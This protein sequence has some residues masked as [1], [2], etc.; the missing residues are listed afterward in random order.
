MTTND[1]TG[2]SPVGHLLTNAHSLAEAG[3]FT[4]AL[5]ATRQAKTLEPKNVYVL[6]FEKQT[7]Q[8]MEFSAAG[9][10][11]EEQR[12]DILE[13]MPVI[14]EK[15][16]ELSR[17]SSGV[18]VI[19]GLGSSKSLADI[20]RE[21][22]EKGAALE[23][24]KNQY[25]QH[26][27]EYVRKGEYHH[28]LAEIRRVYIIDTENKVARDFEKQIDQLAQM[29]TQHATKVHPSIIPPEPEGSPVNIT[30]R[31]PEAQSPDRDSVPM[32]TEEWSSPREAERQ[33]PAKKKHAP[34]ASAKQPEGKGTTFLMVMI[35]LALIALGAS[36][37]WYYQRNYLSR[38]PGVDRRALPPPAS[39]QFLGAPGETAEQSFV[40]APTSADTSNTS[41]QVIQL[42]SAPKTRKE[43]PATRQPA[44]ATVRPTP[45][46]TA[47]A[48]APAS[49]T[50]GRGGP[51]P[52]NT[53]GSALP[54]QASTTAPR[55]AAPAVAENVDSGTTTIPFTAVEKEATII[56]L[57]KPVFSAEAFQRGVLGQVVI[58]VEIDATGKPLETVTLKSTNDLLIQPVINA[59]MASKFAPAEVS[60]GP[61]KSWLTI[62]FKFTAK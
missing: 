17:T 52:V 1:G 6:A 27:H 54:L 58:S 4:A 49:G 55:E 5:A 53:A 61:V 46:E 38:H 2:S 20:E 51:P 62:P 39:E 24:L 14:I 41:P 21:R 34:A 18:T 25:F 9:T 7:E 26:A 11:T 12:S 42:P 44:T 48:M 43:T 60:S 13:S 15:A 22:T 10:V 29:K 32:V 28:A 3:D 8:L 19:S 40:I 45:R 59:V 47:Q 23:W 33:K 35:F 16:V 56:K 31:I 50:A 36:I 37:L 57:E 30:P